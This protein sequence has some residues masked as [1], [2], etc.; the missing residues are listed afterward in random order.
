MTPL[1]ADGLEEYAEAHVTPLEP[2]LAENYDETFASLTSPGMIAGPVLGRLLRFLVAMSAPRL[3]LEIGTFSGYSALAMAG[4]LPAGGRI[5]TCE[6]SP[7]RADFARR[8]FERSPYG[9]RIDV[10]VGPALDTIAGLDGPFDFVF[11]DADKEG[12]TGYYEAVVPKLSPRGVIVADNTLAGGDV[13]APLD[14]R[15]RGIAAFNDHVQADPRTENVLLTVRD[16]VTVIR[17]AA[18]P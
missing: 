18:G 8:Y 3:V 16:G 14:E 2:L 11:I 7:E 13:V 12:Y 6:L 15:D 10:R 17:R 9:D 1:L 4:G 5:V